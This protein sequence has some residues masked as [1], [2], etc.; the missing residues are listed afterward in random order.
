MFSLFHFGGIM[1]DMT[2]CADL[3][4][5]VLGGNDLGEIGR[6]REVLF[7]AANTDHFGLGPGDI[8]VRGIGDVFCTR[9][10]TNLAR[11]LDMRAGGVLFAFILVTLLAFG[12]LDILDRIRGYLIE[13]LSTIVSVPIE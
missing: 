7:V 13:R 1:R 5:A 3:A 6:P 8:F 2:G 11:D 9:A 10:V 12:G 4:L